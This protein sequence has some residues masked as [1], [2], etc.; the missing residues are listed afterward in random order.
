M[1]IKPLCSNSAM[2]L[3]HSIN[4]EILIRHAEC[5]SRVSD[6]SYASDLNSY[7]VFLNHLFQPHGS[8]CLLNIPGTFYLKVFTQAIFFFCLNFS[9]CRHL[10]QYLPSLNLCFNFTF[11]V[12]PPLV[13]YLVF[14]FTHPPP[15]STSA[16]SIS[17]R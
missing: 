11:S 6:L 7:P 15:S 16:F 14:L 9:F 1:K 12:R 10:P 17:L 5:Q 4:S 2:V 3:F 13:L 8:S